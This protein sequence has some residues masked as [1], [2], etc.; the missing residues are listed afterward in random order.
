MK[1]M[2]CLLM[3]L[4]FLLGGCA[5]VPASTDPTSSTA[6]TA[7][8]DYLQ[9]VIELANIPA[10]YQPGELPFEYDPDRTLFVLADYCS[11][12]FIPDREGSNF[13]YAYVYSRKHIAPEDIQV[14]I[15]CQTP[16][17]ISVS[18]VSR[19]FTE[20]T[21]WDGGGFDNL[22]YLI[23]IGTDFGEY[24]RYNMLDIAAS[25]LYLASRE[26]GDDEAAAAYSQISQEYST[27]YWQI[28]NELK[29]VTVE[30]F[31]DKPVYAYHIRI[32]FSMTELY[33]ETVENIAILVEGEKHTVNIGQWRFHS[34]LP[35][36]LIEPM[37]KYRKAADE[38]PG[39]DVKVI[40]PFASAYSDG[41]IYGDGI[42][43]F[44]AEEDMT[45]LGI[46]QIYGGEDP[47]N[48]LG[49][50]VTERGVVYFW[51]FSRPLEIAKG[52]SVKIDLYFR[53]DLFETFPMFSCT[54]FRLDCQIRQT[55]V[56]KLAFINI[57][58]YA[59][60]LRGPYLVAFEGKDL[61]NY[62]Y[63]VPEDEN[64]AAMPKEWRD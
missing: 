3:C 63:W 26:S 47:I 53:D 60:S 5:T 39:S 34:Q 21:S 58:I 19:N 32:N 44:T 17:Q 22:P 46:E 12:D 43:N 14:Q 40:V 51:D 10:E 8:E 37:A 9:N 38:S 1:R 30:N 49:A 2:L 33:D 16:Y 45:L 41:Y 50:R 56:P 20:D 4:I 57:A 35:E 31:P 18:D 61:G 48:I 29:S 42:F 13:A 24:Q 11:S 25:K 7:Y 54:A 23:Y 27:K 64:L 36:D 59:L 15:A 28:I 55:V 62:F 6:T 52:T